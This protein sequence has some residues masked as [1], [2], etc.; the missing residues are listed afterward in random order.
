[1]DNIQ[2]SKVFNHYPETPFRTEIKRNLVSVTS[3]RN[4]YRTCFIS[5]FSI[6][7][8]KSYRITIEYLNS[9]S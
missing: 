2:V 3:N 9:V 1:M 5:A 4:I 6:E 7:A 8:E